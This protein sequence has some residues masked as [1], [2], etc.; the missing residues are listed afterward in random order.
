MQTVDRD[1]VRSV[2]EDDADVAI[3]ETSPKAAGRAG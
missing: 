1:H 2:L 3:V